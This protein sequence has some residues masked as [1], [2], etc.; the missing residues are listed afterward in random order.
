[1]T[2]VVKIQSR[3]KTATISN[4]QIFYGSVKDQIVSFVDDDLIVVNSTVNR[5]PSE[6]YRYI[7]WFSTD[8]GYGTLNI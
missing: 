8:I 5:A 6:I 4:I 7:L 2:E 1:M 3:T